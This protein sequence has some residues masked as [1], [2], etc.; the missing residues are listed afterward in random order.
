MS[1]RTLVELAT[2]ALRGNPSAG[3]VQR[4][5]LFREVS[6]AELDRHSLELAAALVTYG[7][8]PGAR[9]ALLT[10]DGS[11]E[12]LGLLAVLRAGGTAV[13]LDAGATDARIL[14][15]L[16]RASVRQVLVSDEAL[17]RRI[18]AIRP[19]AS[20]LDLVFLFRGSEDDRTAALTVAGAC[21]V[22]ADALCREPGL[23]PPEAATG[24]MGPAV[25]RSSDRG[26]ILLDH[27]QV[28][29]AAEVAGSALGIQRGDT[30]LSALPAPDAAHLSLALACLLRGARLVHV[31]PAERLGEAL[32]A[33]RPGIAVLPSSLSGVL[34]RHLET[35]AGAR[36]WLGSR[37]LHFALS[38]GAK[39][40]AAELAAGRLPAAR[41]WG[42]RAA[43]ALVIRRIG[44]AVGSRLTSLASLGEPLPAVESGFFLSLGLPFL[45]GL[46]FPEAGGLVAMS[47]SDALRQGTAG[48]LVP[49]LEARV[50]ADG[51]L[52]IKGAMVA[53][54]GWRRVPLRGRLDRDGYL[55]G[56]FRG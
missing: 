56:T 52:E 18:L 51:A 43:Q 17:L 9:A 11:E 16:Q 54:G 55:A 40:G 7:L 32:G 22:G 13:P 14:E 46:A 3:L 8:E 35:A 30:V 50:G 39:R 44:K 28:L 26:E 34:R 27:P 6:A 4:G 20:E 15:I 45:E 10:A 37:L 33:A 41:T 53:G 31:H 42:W 48:R 25:L 21:A 47:R 24:A 23:L 38:Q 12:M 36:S 49:G 1:S 29:A 19:E 5:G 2:A